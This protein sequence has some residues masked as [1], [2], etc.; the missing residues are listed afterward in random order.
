MVAC[1]AIREWTRQYGGIKHPEV[2]CNESIHPAWMKAFYYMDIKVKMM[3][4]DI[5]TGTTPLKEW[6][7]NINKNTMAILMSNQTYP[8]GS[9]DPI[10]DMNTYLVKN[11]IN[12]WIA[13]DSCLGGYF[14]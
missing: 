9:I 7:K 4:I 14:S 11:K 1:Y 5:T 2:L 12:A 6:I 3:K 13:I 8:H 10:E